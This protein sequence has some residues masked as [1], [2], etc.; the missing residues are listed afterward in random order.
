MTIAGFWLWPHACH[1]RPLTRINQVLR[2][3]QPL[4]PSQKWHE[5]WDL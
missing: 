4:K 3:F 2:G 5:K 1:E